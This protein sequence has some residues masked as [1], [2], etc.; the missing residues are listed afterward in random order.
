MGEAKIKRDLSPE[1]QE[2]GEDTEKLPA[3]QNLDNN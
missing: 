1:K 3:I 2:Q